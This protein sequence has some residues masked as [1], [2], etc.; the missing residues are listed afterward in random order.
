MPNAATAC[1][2]TD[3]KKGPEK[4]RFNFTP[5]NSRQV[6]IRGL[7]SRCQNRHPRPADTISHTPA[8]WPT[9]AILEGGK[10][11]L[12]HP[13]RVLCDRMGNW[14]AGTFTLAHLS[15]S[16]AH[17]SRFSKRGHHRPQSNMRGTW[18][19]TIPSVPRNWHLSTSN[20]YFPYS[21]T[22]PSTTTAIYIFVTTS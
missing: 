22:S 12:P 14:E 1:E 18:V 7:H 17:S 16:A 4:N 8:A 15:T 20:S 10:S 3:A 19:G 11:R 21:R 6:F 9:C 13:C 5:K 2:M